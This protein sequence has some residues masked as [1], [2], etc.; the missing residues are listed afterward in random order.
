MT[1]W[2]EV[3]LA[4]T[5]EIK[6]YCVKSSLILFTSVIVYCN[7]VLSCDELSFWLFVVFIIMPYKKDF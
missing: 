4:N 6:V 5:R 3:H 2:L 7:Y 1:V